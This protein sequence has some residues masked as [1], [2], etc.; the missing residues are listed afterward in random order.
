MIAS[1]ITYAA[2][3]AFAVMLSPASASM[4]INFV[5]SIVEDPCYINPES[6]AISVTCRQNNEPH[7]RQVSYADAEKGATPFRDRASISMK[8]INPEK[9]LAILEVDYL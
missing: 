2:A 7:T 9:T 4:T 8:Y 5:G 1:R 3:F 6:R